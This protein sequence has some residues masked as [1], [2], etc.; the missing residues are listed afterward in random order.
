MQNSRLIHLIKRLSKAELVKF[1]SYLFGLY[2]RQK[3]PLKLFKHLIKFYPKFE[4]EKL[5]KE[6]V[7][8]KV[9][10][11]KGSPVKRVSNEAH[12]IFEWL[13]DF[14][15]AEKLKSDTLEREKYIIEILK[16]KKLD[17]LFYKKSGQVT[18]KLKDSA[19]NIWDYLDLTKLNH[20]QYYYSPTEKIVQEEE[21]LTEAYANLKIF[22]AIASLKYECELLNRTNI[23][24]KEEVKLSINRS[25]IG[26]TFF[27]YRAKP[28]LLLV[29][30][31]LLEFIKDP[32]AA[33][34][35]ELKNILFEEQDAISSEDQLILLSYLINY[36]SFSAK[37][38]NENGLLDAFELYKFGIENAILIESGFISIDNFR[39]TIFLACE[40]S[41]FN[42]ADQFI[43]SNQKYLPIRYRENICALSYARIAFGR[44]YFDRALN[45][46]NDIEFKNNSYILLTKFIQ[47]RCY[48][49]LRSIFPEV[50]YNFIISFDVFLARN[51]ML[52]SNTISAYRSFLRIL[53]LLLRSGHILEAGDM[54][55]ELEQQ[56]FLVGRSW[57][58]EKIQ[59]YPT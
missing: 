4:N 18:K 43:K 48:Y 16:E 8:T 40:L 41:K 1:E 59:S 38:G 24:Q 14:L 35:Q 26:K 42:W 22:F 54:L 50:L 49:E 12:K 36:A 31:K 27:Q 15:I 34:F 47:V 55:Q 53:R 9:L 11:L 19:V 45:L 23:L 44:K 39:N 7:I 10:E 58:I 21:T 33:R 20:E 25:F 32:D 5:S 52:N 13:L 30:E 29:F 57:L 28:K 2:H 3:I 46:L 51:K 6:Y 17:G 37:K 56:E